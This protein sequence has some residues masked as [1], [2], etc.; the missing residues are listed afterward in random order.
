MAALPTD[1][2]NLLENTIKQARI[3]AE[4]GARQA[5]DALAVGRHEP[6]GSMSIEERKL[7]NRLR[8]H[9]RQLGDVLDGR[10]GTQTIHRLM[11]EVA[12]EQWHRMLFARFLA[13]NHLLIHPEHGVSVSLEEC[14][15]LARGTGDDPW[16]LAAS[17][18]QAMLPQ[19]FRADDPALSVTL[20]PE[21]RVELQK[22]LASL[23]QRVFTEDD[24]LGWTYQFWQSAEKDAVNERAKSGEKITGETLPAVT[25]LFTE[26]YMVHFLLD[27]TVGAWH[28]GKVLTEAQRTGA[29]SEAELREAVRLQGAGGYEFEYLRFVREPGVDDERGDE[30]GH[31]TGP[32]RPAAGTFEGWPRDAKDLTILDPCCGSGHFLVSAF[33]LL[34]PLRMAEEGLSAA[35]AARAVIRDNLFGLEL[36]ARCT[37]IAAFNVALA[38]WKVAGAHIDLPPLRI[39]CSGVGP[40]ATKEEWLKLAEEAAAA[41]G[42]PGEKNVLG[43][44]E[45]LLSA[46]VKGGLEALYDLFQRA[47]DLGSLIDVRGGPGTP[48][49]VDALQADFA[50]LAPLMDAILS[51]E[52]ASAEEVER[53]VAAKGMAEAARVLAGPPDGYTL[54]I[55]NVPY[56]GRGSHTD[57]FKAWAD[58]HYR[59]ARND[60]A[61]I[62]LKRM[63]RW[64]GSGER[65]G[66]IAAV[67]PQNWLFLTTYR[68]LRER[69]LKERTWEM[70][71]R[72]GPGAFETISG[73]V[74]NVALVTVSGGRAFDAH[75]MAG[76]EASPASRPLEKASLLRGAPVELAEVDGS[77]VRGADAGAPDADDHEERDDSGPADGSVRVIPQK[78]QLGNPDAVITF[79]TSEATAFLH[80]YATAWQGVATSDNPRF[81]RALWEVQEV[82]GGWV[83]QQSTVVQ[84]THFGGRS[85]ILFWEDGHGAMTG[86]CQGGATFRGKEAWG[87]PGVVVSQMGT[88]PTTLY[89]GEVFDC[90][91]S[92]VSPL[93]PAI[94]PALWAFCSSSEYH[95]EV[96]RINQKM[97]VTNSSLAKVPFDLDRWQK[98]ADEQ[99]PGGLPEPYSDDPTQWLF[100]GHPAH[101][102]SGT[103]LHV[104]L[105]RL[106]GYRWPAE[107]D[108]EMRLSDEARALI[109]RSAE[110]DALGHTDDDGIVCLS[111]VR[112][113]GSA[114]DRL[115]ALL[116]AAFGDTWSSSNE[117][118]LLVATAGAGHGTS[119]VA[120]NLD[121]WLRDS[122]F[123]EHCKL[124]QHRPFIWHI[125]DGHRDGFN[126]LVNY[127][128]LSGEDGAG[129][130]ALE[131]LTYTY[132]GEWIDRQRKAQENGEEGADGRLAAAIKLQEELRCILEGEPPYDIFVRWKPLH[133]QPAG[134]DPDVNDG[135]RLNIRPFM[136]ADDVRRTGAGVLRWK[137]NIKWTKDR[138]KEPEDLRPREDFPWFWGCDPEE[139][140]AHRVDFGAGTPN[141]AP[142]GA[143]FDGARWNGG[144]YTRAAK[145][146]ARA[147]AEGGS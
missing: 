111:P 147:R 10:R 44:E 25:Q 22:L 96:R 18:A 125:W 106:L 102:E 57:E 77:L 48:D 71:A 36:D 85:G 47:P 68:K 101:A 26:P 53:A 46:G 90:N 123:E 145:A 5:L 129:R 84:T 56:L 108:S 31:A 119:K 132:L 45:S 98:V 3:E 127:H 61:T 8:A 51:R 29:T 103:E 49:Q 118:E 109:R 79:V 93:D 7:R 114:A 144:H 136:L 117:R 14:E 88:L 58:T 138:G 34:V 89:G 38:A 39:A 142:A 124:F 62:F 126:A 83:F 60:L 120:R 99:Y 16:A 59:E 54:V 110:L 100:H 12:Y 143:A 23:P 35:D 50:D 30:E 63:L 131:S 15:D 95:S 43:S 82:G 19:I 97:N 73:H 107:S 70:V 42:M 80:D 28:A 9:G 140:A 4:K 17:F 66:T 146:A 24:A 130:K 91:C 13:E 139:E 64:V 67:T 81:T 137:P 40:Q 133:E 2:R 105:A 135:V 104:A 92:I 6:H 55:T 37:Q 121:A 27:N 32:W 33:R 78:A 52:G 69:L 113:E 76:V 115:R 134:W 41:G 86:V 112:G 65:A 94:V 75:A 1:L 141:A 128:R 87:R 21:A 72:L 116:G 20:P 74:V 122:F 11:R